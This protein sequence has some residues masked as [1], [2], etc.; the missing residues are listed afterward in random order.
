M[1]MNF[2]FFYNYVTLT[3]TDKLRTIRRGEGGWESPAADGFFFLCRFLSIAR[4]QTYCQQDDAY[5][6]YLPTFIYN[7]LSSS[8]FKIQN[9]QHP[10]S[11]IY[12]Y[13]RVTIDEFSSLLNLAHR[14]TR[15]KLA[16]KTMERLK[17]SETEWNVYCWTSG[18]FLFLWDWQC[19]AP[20]QRLVSSSGLLFFLVWK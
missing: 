10:N 6:K 2:T 9:T 19:S 20:V 18:P 3:N 1:A 8:R 17:G 5:S 11:W 12:T 15:L 7:D 13:A 4:L 16:N 14:S